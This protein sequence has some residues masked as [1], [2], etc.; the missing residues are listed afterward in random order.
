MTFDN[1]P[2]PHPDVTPHHEAFGS[3]VLYHQRGN[4]AWVT[5]N[6]RDAL[7]AINTATAEQLSKLWAHVSAE[8]HVHTVVLTGAGPEAF[9]IGFGRSTVPHSI[10]PKQ[11]G[12]DKRLIVAVN[13]IACREA[14]H[15][16]QDADLVIAAERAVFFEARWASPTVPDDYGPGARLA[17]WRLTHAVRRAPVTAAE[18]YRLGV[19]QETVPLSHLRSATEHLAGRLPSRHAL[20]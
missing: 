4:V 5:L 3:T 9:S 14:F 7:N 2:T 18:A 20:W 16:L 1:C 19:I 13:G 10:S 11:C 8:P 15:L 6:R 12:L 17:R